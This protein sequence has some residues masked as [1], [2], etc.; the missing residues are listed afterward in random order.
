[1]CQCRGLPDALDKSPNFIDKTMGPH[2][3]V[4]VHI[5]KVSIFEEIAFVV[6]HDGT[7]EVNGGVR[8]WRDCF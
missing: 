5:H 8:G 1:M 3:L 4:F 6:V 2:L 7:D